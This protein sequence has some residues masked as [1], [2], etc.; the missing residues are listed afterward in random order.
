MGK[1]RFEQ[2]GVIT[3]SSYATTASY[4]EN[5]GGAGVDFITGGTVETLTEIEV[6][7]FDN[8]VAVTFTDGRLKLIFGTPTEPSALV[9]SFNGTFNTNRFNQEQDNYTITGT[10]TTGAYTFLSASFWE[11]YV[12]LT[13]TTGG[14][15]SNLVYNT[16]TSG[17][18]T[19]QLQYTASSPLDGSIYTNSY[20]LSGTLSKTQPS[21]PTISSTATVQLGASSFQIE[22]GATGS[23]SFTAAYGT[24]NGWSETGLITT[25]SVSPIYV[26]GSATGSSSITI[27]GVAYYESPSGL[28]VPTITT[29]RSAA[30]TTYS[31]IRS[32]RHG[33]SIVT[34]F[35]TAELADLALWDTTLGGSVGTI[36]K[37]T[38]NPS[39]QSVT[40]TWTGDKYHYI[41]F[42]SSR[43][44]LSNIT[45]SG[46]GVLA[47]FTVTTVGSYK[48]YKTAT[49]QAGGAGTSITYILT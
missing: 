30:T 43:N 9:S 1:P 27:T 10:W 37:G 21:N 19:Y 11:N 40:I 45:T 16:T 5:A 31:K 4:A 14:N 18:H 22:Q 38:T 35:T 39:G 12:K 7:D 49:L 26:T 23:I 24:A 15:P 13:E 36:N 28:N 17:S 29:N 20:N 41:V 44:N 34:S 2:L 32:L 25:P 8:N 6:A 46:F 3:S 42:D 48:I 47:S 33:A